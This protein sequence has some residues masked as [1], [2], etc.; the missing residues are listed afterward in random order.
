M[1]TF[2][3]LSVAL[4]VLLV[5]TV[6]VSA[7]AGSVFLVIFA[8]FIVFG[9]IVWGIYKAYTKFKRRVS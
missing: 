9:L 8:D 1:I 7:F 3:I 5:V 4:L 6:L 2:I